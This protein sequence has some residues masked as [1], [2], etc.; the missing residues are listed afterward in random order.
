MHNNFIL[1][2]SYIRATSSYLTTQVN[3]ILNQKYYTI[4]IVQ[5]NTKNTILEPYKERHNTDNTLLLS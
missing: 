5:E 3:L 1:F 4:K 2:H